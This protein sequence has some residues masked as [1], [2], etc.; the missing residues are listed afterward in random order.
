MYYVAM[1]NAYI[2]NKKVNILHVSVSVS[3]TIHCKP[4]AAHPAHIFGLLTF[5]H[6][7]FFLLWWD[8]TLHIVSRFGFS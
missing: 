8:S 3:Q 7:I 6:F 1:Q 2:I 4:F 5:T